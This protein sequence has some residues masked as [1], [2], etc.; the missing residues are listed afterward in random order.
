M[1]IVGVDGWIPV[2]DIPRTHGL[3][4]CNCS[5]DLALRGLLD[6]RGSPLLA[7]K[8]GNEAGDAITGHA[9]LTVLSRRASAW[10][11]QIPGRSTAT[12]DTR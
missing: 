9:Q 7:L 8:A 2:G 5:S 11:C 10:P 1:E 12:G 3:I 6:N 4:A